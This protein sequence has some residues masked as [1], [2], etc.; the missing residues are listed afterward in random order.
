VSG[1]VGLVVGLA[2]VW[3]PIVFIYDEKIEARSASQYGGNGSWVLA[4]AFA[5][6]LL[7]FI[8]L[9]VLSYSLLRLALTGKMFPLR[10][11]NTG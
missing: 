9:T 4:G 2:A 1:G 11:R 10:R 6:A 8:A 5:F 3:L 7:M